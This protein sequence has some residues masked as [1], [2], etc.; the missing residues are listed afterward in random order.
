[1]LAGHPTPKHYTPFRSDSLTSYS[2]EGGS[3]IQPLSTSISVGFTYELQQR[4]RSVLAGHSAP[5]HYTPSWSDSLT[6]YSSEG[7]QC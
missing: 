5:R 7:G 4:G 2:S 6:S 3:V 1:M